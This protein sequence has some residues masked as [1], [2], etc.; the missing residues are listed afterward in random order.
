MEKS[1]RMHAIAVYVYAYVGML[2]VKPAALLVIT[3]QA[4]HALALRAVDLLA[5]A[6]MRH[7]LV[8]LVSL[9]WWV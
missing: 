6:A 4:H 2:Q 7:N 5:S 8:V 9:V 3:R 1:L